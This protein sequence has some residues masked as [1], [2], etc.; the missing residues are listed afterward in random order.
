MMR[1]QD[2]SATASKRLQSWMLRRF[3]HLVAVN[4][5]TI[6]GVRIDL[7][8]N[9]QEEAPPQIVD[10]GYRALQVPHSAE[11]TSDAPLPAT[12]T[13]ALGA[14]FAGNPW[15]QGQVTLIVPTHEIS[16]RRLQFPFR[17]RRQVSG[18][19]SYALESELL[20][21]LAQQAYDF[22]LFPAKDRNAHVNVFLFRRNLLEEW[23]HDCQVAGLSLC[24]VTF[25]A[26]VLHELYPPPA[27]GVQVQVYVG[28][29]EVF[30]NHSVD[31]RQ[32]QVRVISSALR[33]LLD[34]LHY[35]EV[36]NPQ[37]LWQ[38]MRGEKTTHP[39]N[40][41]LVHG[42]IKMALSAVEME[43][44]RFLRI[45]T[46]QLE[47]PVVVRGCF[48]SCFTWNAEESKLL[49]DWDPTTFFQQTP[50][51]FYG[52]LSES[53]PP[54][55]ALLTRGGF[56]FFDGR[57]VWGQF[58]RENRRQLMTAAM[59]CF[60]LLGQIGLRFYDQLIAQRSMLLQLNQEI[61]LRVK[62]F[63]PAEGI[64]ARSSLMT[65][66]SKLVQQRRKREEQTRFTRD[67]Q[68][69]L[70]L[71]HTLALVAQE[72]TKFNVQNFQVNKTQLV[73]SGETESYKDSEVLKDRLNGLVWLRAG[74][75]NL[76]HS[77]NGEKIGYRLTVERT[78]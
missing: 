27:N 74:K 22:D 29:D 26:R 16:I 70:Q 17:N 20:A 10:A 11:Q 39:V 19:L 75:I 28:F 12:S 1:I 35:L 8:A 33:A 3:Y 43:I 72:E 59:L 78:P 66:E 4:V 71:L 49:L 44:N 42:Q 61:A 77:R 64:T 65:L 31:G 53:L 30:I 68:P 55:K 40:A 52:I 38:A 34:H 23:A 63:P 32:H 45:H 15:S 62:A 50:P 36:P 57:R 73:M 37:A 2:M 18:A 9:T 6:E 76:T 41:M 14:F 46:L 21:P 48:S 56:S 5:S 47:H 24:K 58:W 60:L 7:H 51:A 67:K 69:I 13:S 25:S 54:P